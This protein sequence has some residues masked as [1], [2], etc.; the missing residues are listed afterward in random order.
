M[1]AVPGQLLCID[2][3]G[4][5]D[6]ILHDMSLDHV[7]LDIQWMLNNVYRIV[8]VYA[9]KGCGQTTYFVRYRHCRKLHLKHHNLGMGFPSQ[10]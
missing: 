2:R 7:R 9:S 1:I 5:F 3:T 8:A 4:D 6:D 10:R